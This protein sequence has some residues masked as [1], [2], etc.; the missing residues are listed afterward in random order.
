MKIFQKDFKYFLNEARSREL[1]TGI[2]VQCNANFLK[3]SPVKGLIA[4]IV[5]IF[6]TAHPNKRWVFVTNYT[7]EFETT[8][9]DKRGGELVET[10]VITINENQ[11]KNLIPLTQTD[12]ERIKSGYKYRFD[13]SIRFQM[14]LRSIKF[15]PEY[16]YYDASYFDIDKNGSVTLLPGNKISLVP[17][18]D[19]YTSK[20]RTQTKITR[21]IQKFNE[22]LTPQEVADYGNQ[23]T[24]K[25]KELNLNILDR[26]KVVTGDEITYWYHENRYVQGLGPLNKSCMRYAHTQ[27]RVKFYSKYPDKIAL[28]I[29]LDSTKKKIVARA[30]VWRLDKPAGEIFMDR[31]YYVRQEYEAVMANYAYNQGWNTKLSGYHK[32]HQMYVEIPYQ[33]EITLPYLDSFEFDGVK[34]FKNKT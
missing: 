9:I 34:G 20:F 4:K 12:L 11:I 21:V 33:Y 32:N 14:I 16:K 17:E 25:W 22:K 13:C 7:L 30:L 3:V 28:C 18:K 1:Y 26:I 2:Y 8:L 23:F 5:R 6:S 29:L 19:R 24:A 27:D 15:L 10:N 31:I